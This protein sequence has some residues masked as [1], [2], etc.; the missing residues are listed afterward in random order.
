M[1]M[2]A[3][4]FGFTAMAQT[5]DGL[6]ANEIKVE[7]GTTSVSFDLCLKN[8]MDVAAVSFRLGLPDGVGMTINKKGM[9]YITLNDDRMYAHAY[10]IQDAEDGSDMISIYDNNPFF[11][12]DGA[13]ATIPLTLSEEIAAVD[14]TYEVKMYNI[15]VA[16]P[17]GNSLTVAGLMPEEFT[18]KLIIGEGSVPTPPT[19]PTPE[20]GDGIYFH[21]IKVEQGFTTTT[22]EVCLKNSVDVAAVSMR[23]GLPE[24][25]SMTL[26]KKGM[27]YITLNDDRM[28]SHA[29]KIQDAEDGSDMI[30][31]YDNNPFYEND[32]VLFSIPL[33]ISEELAAVG[34]T[35][36]IKLYNISIANPAGESYTVNGAMPTEFTSKLTIVPN[37]PVPPVT[38]EG[39]AS[40][41]VEDIYA[42]PDGKSVSYVEVLLDEKPAGEFIVGAQFNLALP[43]GVSIAQVYSEDDE[44]YVDDIT[45][46]AAKSS[47]TTRVAKTE[48]ANEYQFIVADDVEHFKTSTKVFCKIGL[49]VDK[50][51][52]AGDYNLNFSKIIFSY[53]NKE[54]NNKPTDYPQDDFTAKLTVSPTGDLN[55][56]GV[57]GITDAI[58]ILDELTKS[59]PSADCDLNEDGHVS[60]S[61]YVMVLQIMAA[62][63]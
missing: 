50:G 17:A 24:G 8:S 3:M 34:G 9:K 30:S 19:P 62:A 16:D 59:T 54:E 60:V 31:V 13:L 35:F 12:N 42:K 57:V 29:Y 56:D 37:P 61:D 48:N 40:I 1:T 33:T 44:E 51:V 5:E 32:G 28:Y 63:N 36:D 23:L 46:P 18:F 11:E 21:D 2:V 4:L 47:H 6:Y 10:K 15:S 52:V 27:K 45:W 7:K 25:V 20:E 53:L 58:Y 43:A 22:L 14:G 49:V 41:S 26:N 38:Q 39:S 55:G